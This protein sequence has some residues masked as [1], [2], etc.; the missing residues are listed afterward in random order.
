MTKTKIPEQG[1]GTRRGISCP[2]KLL[3]RCLF[4]QSLQPNYKIIKAF[5][6]LAQ[7]NWQKIT[8]KRKEILTSNIPWSWW[9]E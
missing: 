9:V 5:K 3:D 4:L 7:L 2:P 8:T 6:T 1:S